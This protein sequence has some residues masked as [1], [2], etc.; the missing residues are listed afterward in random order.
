MRAVEFILIRH[1]LPERI[2]NSDGPADPALTEVGHEQANRLARWLATEPIAHIISSP[3]LRARQTAEPLARE[4][5]LQVEIIPEFS[6]IDR[7]SSH[8]IPIEELRQEKHE[9]YEMMKNQQWEELG[10]LEPV[11][12]RREVVEAFE[13]LVGRYEQGDCVAIVAHGATLNAIA[14]HVIGLDEMFFAHLDYTSIS[15][16]STNDWNGSLRLATI[17]ETAH[18]HAARDVLDPL[19]Y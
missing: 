5:R 13:R 4:L 14:A 3:K 15:R 6:E 18:L 2:E 11:A 19:H 7:Q 16:L 10:Y 17:N 8:Y 9:I 12:F 1:G